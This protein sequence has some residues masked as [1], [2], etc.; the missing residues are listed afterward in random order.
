M[1]YSPFEKIVAEHHA[2]IRLY[3][4]RV[5]HGADTDT[6]CEETFVRAFRAHRSMPADA[7]VRGWLF[8]I[9]TNL[10]RKSRAVRQSRLAKRESARP[11]AP[12]GGPPEGKARSAG[13]LAPL[14]AAI[15][16][17]AVSRRLALVMRKLHHLDY[18]TIGACLD[19]SAETARM[20]VLEAMR[21]IVRGAVRD[22]HGVA[23]GSADPATRE[24]L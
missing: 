20:L 9:A 22:H 17:L 13:R 12:D 19:C 3:L 24:P 16:R 10:C 23:R 21:R 18:P 8:A 6:L 11:D 5:A 15:A 1:G 4:G 2:E 7:D 14:E